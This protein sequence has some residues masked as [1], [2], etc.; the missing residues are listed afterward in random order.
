MFQERFPFI[1]ESV[2]PIVIDLLEV[3][4]MDILHTKIFDLLLPLVNQVFLLL[5]LLHHVSMLLLIISK[6]V[7]Q[8]LHLIGGIFNESSQK[9][10]SVLK[11]LI[12]LCEFRYRFSEVFCFAIALSKLAL[13]VQLRFLVEGFVFLLPLLE[14]FLE[15][16]LI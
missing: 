7:F 13:Q 1:F 16:S 14:H 12:L 4:E 5:K 9:L 11:P 10:S 2:N 6:L 8:I 3:L 15:F